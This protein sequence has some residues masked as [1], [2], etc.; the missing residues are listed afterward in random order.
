MRVGFIGL[1][2]MGSRMAGRLLAAHYEV[3]VY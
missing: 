1:G 3:V 2:A